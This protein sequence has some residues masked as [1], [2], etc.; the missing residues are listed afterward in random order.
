M[1]AKKSLIDKI[2]KIHYRTLQI[3]YDVCN[4][5]YKSFKKVDTDFENVT[6]SF[7]IQYFCELELPKN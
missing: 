5:S 7:K 4:E 1:F 3:V 2:L 6:R